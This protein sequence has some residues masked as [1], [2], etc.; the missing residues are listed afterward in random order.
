MYTGFTDD[1]TYFRDELWQTLTGYEGIIAPNMFDTTSEITYLQTFPTFSG[2]L[3]IDFN[4]DI[5]TSYCGGFLIQLV[6]DVY[7]T[8]D[9]DLRAFWDCTDMNLVFEDE[10][11]S[12]PA[13]P[14]SSN[15]EGYILY[16]KDPRVPF[17][18]YGNPMVYFNAFDNVNIQ[19]TVENGTYLDAQQL[20]FGLYDNETS[21]Q[22]MT[23]KKLSYTSFIDWFIGE[24]YMWDYTRS[25]T[26]EF[27]NY[28]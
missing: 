15:I 17:E 27:S 6:D 11:D 19:T 20:Y 18:N 13:T 12:A 8:T 23:L 5:N 9:G 26:H 10:T 25:S 21:L 16:R 28:R 14:S 2:P 1:F 7:N 24:E 4:I 3:R 22:Y